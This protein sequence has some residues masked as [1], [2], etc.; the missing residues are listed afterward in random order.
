MYNWIQRD[1][2]KQL[3][4]TTYVVINMKSPQNW[5]IP[6]F[7]IFKIQLTFFIIKSKKKLSV[8]LLEFF[9]KKLEMLKMCIL[10]IF[11]KYKTQFFV[12][13]RKFKHLKL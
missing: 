6:K 9:L 13:S 5:K 1:Q 11:E 4:F 10:E 8:K 12:I 3:C 7:K 2:L